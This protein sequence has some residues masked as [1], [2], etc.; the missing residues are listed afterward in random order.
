MPTSPLMKFTP[1]WGEFHALPP[2]DCVKSARRGRILHRVDVGI[3]PYDNIYQQNDKLQFESIISQKAAP[4]GSACLT[5]SKQYFRIPSTS[6]PDASGIRRTLPRLK[7][8]SP[9]LFFTPASP[10]PGFRVHLFPCTKKEDALRASSVLVRRKG[11]DEWYRSRRAG[12]G[13]QST[14]L[15][16]FIVRVPPNIL[17]KPDTQMGIWLFWYA[18]RDSNPQPSEPESDALSIEPPAHL[19]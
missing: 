3:D 5:F 16:H 11:L 19:L 6:V 1:R 7:K 15:L 8:Q 9:G 17:K 13:Q 2:R 4:G 18:G 10:E 14:G 12:I